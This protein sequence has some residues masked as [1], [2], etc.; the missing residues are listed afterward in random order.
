MMDNKKTETIGNHMDGLTPMQVATI[1]ALTKSKTFTDAAEAAGVT[2]QSIRNW[3]RDP[4]FRRALQAARSESFD[5]L[6]LGLLNLAD[7]AMVAL[8]DILDEPS[9]PGF[10]IRRAAANDIISHSTR[11]YEV[12]TLADRIAEIE[13]RLDEDP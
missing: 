4:Q 2:R 1:E 7:K 3:L 11:L 9:T 12:V 10:A 8:E 5:S 13:Y 6:S